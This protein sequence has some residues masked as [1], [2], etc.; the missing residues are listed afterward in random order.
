MREEKKQLENSTIPELVDEVRAGKMSRRQL[1]KTLTI[2]GVSAA[3]AGAI[4]AVAARQIASN[5]S[6][7]HVNGDNNAQQHI[8]QHQQHI[9]N[10]STGNVQQLHNDYHEDAIVEDSMYA[11]PFVGRMAIMARKKAGLAAIP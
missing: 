10:Q 11:A 4:A 7:P 1:M 5:I 3:G 6:A 2:M 9:A 8:Q